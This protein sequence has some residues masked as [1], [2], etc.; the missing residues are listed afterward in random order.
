MTSLHV[1]CGLAPFQ[2]QI[3]ATPMAAQI[4][5]LSGQPSDNAVTNFTENNNMYSKHFFK[6]IYII[7][8]KING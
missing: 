8:I 3:L 7:S 6:K 5:I 4:Q 1:T 2:L